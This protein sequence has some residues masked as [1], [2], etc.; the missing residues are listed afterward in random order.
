MCEINDGMKWEFLVVDD[1]KVN[2]ESNYM[3]NREF[4]YFWYLLESY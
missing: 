2:L 4:Y 3:E 1:I